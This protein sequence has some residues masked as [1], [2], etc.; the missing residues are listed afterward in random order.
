[1]SP[2]VPSSCFLFILFQT[3]LYH[4]YPQ[5]IRIFY[6]TG[7]IRVGYMCT[8]QVLVPI[9]CR[10][11]RDEGR[12]QLMRKCGLPHKVAFYPPRSRHRPSI[13]IH[14]SSVGSM[15]HG[16]INRSRRLA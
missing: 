12:K 8:A 7:E 2:Q 3:V 10:R 6:D 14:G 11:N 15:L 5:F 1:M 4:S 16:C 13:W 9:I